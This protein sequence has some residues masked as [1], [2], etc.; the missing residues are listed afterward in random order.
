MAV[1]PSESLIPL[2]EEDKPSNIPGGI[3]WLNL[4]VLV[5]R[6]DRY[7]VAVCVSRCLYTRFLL[8]PILRVESGEK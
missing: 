2:E 4:V 7:S 6:A 1:W 8:H 5:E 3:C